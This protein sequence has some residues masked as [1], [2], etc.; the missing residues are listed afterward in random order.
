MNTRLTS[1]MANRNLI[2]V[3]SRQTLPEAV[4]LLGDGA[5]SLVVG[6]AAGSV[7][8]RSRDRRSSVSTSA[9]AS[10]VSPS[11][12]NSNGNDIVANTPPTAGPILIPRLTASRFTAIAALRCSGRV[13]A[14]SA[15]IVAGRVASATT[16]Q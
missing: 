3:R 7:N 15:D 10:D 1:R 4:G 8:R 5:A 2:A 12:T 6:M 13:V 16:A 11:T 9:D 14:V